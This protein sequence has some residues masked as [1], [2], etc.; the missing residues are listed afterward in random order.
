MMKTI[1]SLVVMAAVLMGMAAAV[2]YTVG[3]PDGGWD[4][5][6]D[7]QTWSTSLSFV[8]G[9]NLI[10]G[11]TTNHDVTEVSS[12][13]YESCTATN[14]LQPPLTGGAAVVPLTSAGTRYFICGT[15]GHC[16]SGMKLAI[17]TIAASSPPPP[18]TTPAPPPSKTTTP[19]PAP[20]PSKSTTAPSPPPKH[21][22]AVMPPPPQPSASAPSGSALPPP[23]LAPSAAAKVGLV[24]G[25]IVMVLLVHIL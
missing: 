7:L 12:S 6:T 9:D 25:L 21:S 20:P 22:K 2:N 18:S 3:S 15:G 8:E 13:D 4:Q 17:T 23:T 10:F 14:P 16:I 11:Y 5:S 24:G 1:L 19:S